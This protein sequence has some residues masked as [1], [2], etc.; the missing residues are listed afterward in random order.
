MRSLYK[1]SL[2]ALKKT[3]KKSKGVELEK[4]KKPAAK[5]TMFIINPP[6]KIEREVEKVV[7]EPAG[8]VIHEIEQQKETETATAQGPEVTR[9]TGLDQ[10]SRKRKKKLLSQ[11]GLRLLCQ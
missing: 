2:E 10:P 9:I 3:P 1:F 4:P 7:E 8:S 11:K 6:K 5:K